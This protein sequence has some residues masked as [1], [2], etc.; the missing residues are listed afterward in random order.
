MKHNKAPNIVPVGKAWDFKKWLSCRP[1]K[2]QSWTGQHVYRFSL[3]AD[4][5]TQLHYKYFCNSPAYMCLDPKY[6]VASFKQ[7]SNTERTQPEAEAAHRGIPMPT[8]IPDGEPCLAE[9][10]DF[11]MSEQALQLARYAHFGACL[12][13][14]TPRWAVIKM[15]PFAHGRAGQNDDAAAC[16]ELKCLA[17]KTLDSIK[18]LLQELIRNSEK[19][20]A[21]IESWTNKMDDLKNGRGFT[22]TAAWDPLPATDYAA[23]A[24]VE[25]VRDPAICRERY[26]K[27]NVPQ[28]IQ[29][30]NWTA[31]DRKRAEV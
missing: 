3:D 18:K 23:G 22:P 25:V 24:L 29:P 5:H 9:G 28:V 16:S 10:I 8:G 19:R 30:P 13:T 31:S 11:S 4:G 2:L 17:D 20:E 27:E 21:A 15:T 7:L 12:T 6:S 26:V 14:C 1:V